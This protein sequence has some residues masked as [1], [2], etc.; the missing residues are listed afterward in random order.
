MQP[1]TA[2]KAR[3]IQLRKQGKTYSEIMKEAPVAK[4]TISLWLHDVQLAKKT[5]ATNYTKTY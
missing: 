2:E 3:A 1:K 5:N 4:A